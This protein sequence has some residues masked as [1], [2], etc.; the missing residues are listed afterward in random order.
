M[1]FG[2]FFDYRA[3][4]GEGALAGD[5]REHIRK[6]LV[7]TPAFLGHLAQEVVQYRT[8]TGFFGGLVPHT[9][10]SLDL[11]ESLAPIVHIGRLYA[12]RHGFSETSTPGR[13]QRMNELGLLSDAGHEELTQG[14]DFLM[15]LRL[16]HQAECLA[17][18]LPADNLV[19]LKS[20]THLEESLLKHM[21]V[22]DSLREAI[23]QDLAGICG[24]LGSDPATLL[25]VMLDEARYAACFTELY[26]RVGDLSGRKILEVGSG[27][28][29]MLGS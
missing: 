14:Y 26:E 16:R 12:L 21:Q 20:L 24:V 5:L 2:T 10:R 25:P 3:I 9:H 29:A 23:Q 8:S 19:E 13:F 4:H 6:E 15:A 7:A 22:S 1:E 17:S 27:Y 18:G 28:G 11:K